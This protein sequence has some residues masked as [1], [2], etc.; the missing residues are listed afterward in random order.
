[1]SHLSQS[2][3]TVHRAAGGSTFPQTAKLDLLPSPS[4]MALSRVKGDDEI[5]VSGYVTRILFAVFDRFAVMMGGGMVHVTSNSLLPPFSRYLVETSW[6]VA[7]IFI[8][9]L[10]Q[11]FSQYECWAYGIGQTLVLCIRLAFH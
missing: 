11:A 6:T 1:V 8:A 10:V 5:Y 7:G 3:S 9:L 4:D 2:E